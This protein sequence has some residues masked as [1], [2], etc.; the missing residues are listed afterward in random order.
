MST[1][2]LSRCQSTL[3]MSPVPTNPASIPGQLLVRR[4]TGHRASALVRYA[5]VNQ[6]CGLLPSGPSERLTGVEYER[7]MLGRPASFF[8]GTALRSCGAIKSKSNIPSRGKQRR[9]SRGNGGIPPVRS[10]FHSTKRVPEHQILRKCE[11]TLPQAK[12]SAKGEFQ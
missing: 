3:G 9:R 1:N 10:K 4:I 6:A 5:A 11:Q 8:F 12:P 7:A 2:R